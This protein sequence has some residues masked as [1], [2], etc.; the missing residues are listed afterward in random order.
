M[1]MRKDWNRISTQVIPAVMPGILSG[2]DR[3]IR[4]TLVK[5]L[6]PFEWPLLP[7]PPTLLGVREEGF[8][9]LFLVARGVV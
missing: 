2:V 4:I 8:L 5:S 7:S 9:G 1:G 6:L 3:H